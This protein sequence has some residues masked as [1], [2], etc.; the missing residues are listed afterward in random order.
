MTSIKYHISRDGKPRICYAQNSC[1]LGG[2]HYSRAELVQAS[3]PD[4]SGHE[5]FKDVVDQLE[6]YD[7]AHYRIYL[8]RDGEPKAV[9]VQSF[10]YFDYDGSRF[11]TDKA[12]S[13]EKEAELDAKEFNTA[14][15]PAYMKPRKAP[16]Q[17][18]YEN[19][20]RKHK[21]SHE[22][23][24]DVVDQLETYDEAH[25]R[26]YYNRENKVKVVNVQS[27]DY[28]DY[29]GPRFLDTIAF[30]SEEEALESLKKFA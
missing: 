12:Y 28:Y 6:T 29:E 10:D 30:Q 1:P 9:N 19:N 7:E 21:S 17:T 13:D 18:L 23:F 25:Y 11:L 15:A 16:A 14:E 3:Q 4:K 26:L 27:F 2:Q 22:A 8:S 24:T 20:I 5:A